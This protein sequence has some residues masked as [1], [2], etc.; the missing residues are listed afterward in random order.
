M[1]LTGRDVPMG[2]RAKR[3]QHLET[4]LRIISYTGGNLGVDVRKST[5]IDIGS[6]MR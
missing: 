4:I 5:I 2:N 1:D 3:R 6:E